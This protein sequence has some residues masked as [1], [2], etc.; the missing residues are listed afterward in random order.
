MPG[1]ALEEHKN[2]LTPPGLCVIESNFAKVFW[3]KPKWQCMQQCTQVCGRVVY[4]CEGFSLLVSPHLVQPV[5]PLTM[6]STE[7]QSL[8]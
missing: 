8:L 4:R 7:L 2:C 5:S 3:A 1:I 6:K